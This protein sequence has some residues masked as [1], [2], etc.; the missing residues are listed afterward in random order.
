MT[1]LAIA[2]KQLTASKKFFTVWRL[3][4]NVWSQLIIL[5]VYS[6]CSQ[7]IFAT[8]LNPRVRCAFGNVLSCSPV[9][10]VHE[11]PNDAGRAG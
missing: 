8:T 10:V 7:I 5:A 6:L 4:G 3:I 9:S 11:L 2:W 1:V